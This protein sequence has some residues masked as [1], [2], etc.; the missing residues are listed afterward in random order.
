MRV[1]ACAVGFDPKP[2][3]REA[4][5]VSVDRRDFQQMEPILEKKGVLR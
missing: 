5:D 1:G 2:V 3:V 4:A